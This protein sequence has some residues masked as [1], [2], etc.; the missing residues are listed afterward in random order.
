MSELKQTLINISEEKQAKIKPE[1]IKVGVQAFD[2]TGTFTADADAT[3]NDIAKDKIAYVNG[4]KIIGLAEINNNN[5][6]FNTL[7]S[8]GS[9]SNAGLLQGLKGISGNFTTGS[10]ASFIFTSLPNLE[11]IDG[12]VD[13]SNATNMQNAFV[14]CAKLERIPELDT[15]NVTNMMNIFSGCKALKTVSLLHTESVTTFQQSF[16]VATGLESVFLGDTSKATNTKNMFANCTALKIVSDMDLSSVTDATFM[17]D[18][19]SSLETAPNLKFN[20][21]TEC[22]M[23]AMFRNCTNLK[24]VPV[25]DLSMATTWVNSFNSCPNLTYESINNIM[26]TCATAGSSYT[27]A[28]TLINVGISSS[29]YDSATIQGLSNYQTFLDAGWTIGF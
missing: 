10:N 2:V 12:T 5:A 28:K 3:E 19:C 20:T 23:G 14:N 7:I 29:K 13:T 6:L 4:E 21:T 18:V 22:S 15:R 9:S 27:A 8:N 17:F 24:N 25:Y 26:A 16:Q 11:Y 1:N